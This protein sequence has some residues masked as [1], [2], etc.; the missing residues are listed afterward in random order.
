MIRRID[1]RL[2]VTQV[3]TMNEIIDRSSVNSASARSVGGFAIGALL[4]AA[5]DSLA[6][7][8]AR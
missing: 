1:P 4:L 3:R 7:S 8:P 2:A 5:W 6:S